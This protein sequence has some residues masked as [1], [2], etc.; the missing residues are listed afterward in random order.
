MPTGPPKFKHLFPATMVDPDDGSAP[1]TQVPAALHTTGGVTLSTDQ[2]EA[3]MKLLA[4]K[5]DGA[6]P[7]PDPRCGGTDEFGAWA[8]GGNNNKGL[9]PSTGNCYRKIKGDPIKTFPLVKNIQKEVSLGLNGLR[10]TAFS[11]SNEANGGKGMTSLRLVRPL[12]YDNGLDSVFNLVKPDG[13]VLDILRTPGYVTQQLIDTWEADLTT[14]GVFKKDGTGRHPVCEYDAINLIWSAGMLMNSCS[15]ALKLHIREALVATGK[16]LNGLQV[17]IQIVSKC[18]RPSSSTVKTLVLKLEAMDIKKFAGENVTLY[19]Q[20]SKVILQEIKLNVQMDHQIPDLAQSALKG[21]CCGNDEFFK[22]HAKTLMRQVR[23]NLSSTL[24]TIPIEKHLDT[25]ETL[26]LELVDANDYPPGRQTP[27]ADTRHA[28]MTAQMAVMAAQVEEL[29]QFRNASSTRGNSGGA[30]GNGGAN[31]PTEGSG[32]CKKCGSQDHLAAACTL[33]RSE[34]ARRKTTHSVEDW[35][36]LSALVK[37]AKAALPERS[38]I[39]DL[40]ILSIKMNGVVVSEFCRHCNWY[41]KGASMHNTSTHRGSH[42][43]PYV[44]PAAGAPPVVPP[45]VQRPPAVAGMMTQVSPPR[46][47]E[48][49]VAPAQVSWASGVVGGTSLIRPGSYDFGSMVG[50][51]DAAGRLAAAPSGQ[52]FCSFIGGDHNQSCR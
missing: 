3:F 8:G 5:P 50:P 37:T 1:G 25:L 9:V 22:H 41:T 49:E 35:D 16:D 23:V 36:K 40:P 39:P 20:E 38:S 26:Y 14:N 48:S 33:T 45:E 10:L 28:A 42:K 52:D 15:E 2:F 31:A 47:R 7:L 21:L 46:E 30:T 19:N 24:T 27:A 12:S 51:D 17:F 43:F 29:T 13:T 18:Y 34:I 6:T 32:K 44:A 4:V 11:M